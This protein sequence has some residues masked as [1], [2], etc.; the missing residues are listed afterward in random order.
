FADQEVQNIDPEPR[1]VLLD[2]NG[3]LCEGL[4]SN[5]FIVR[6]EE[7]LTPREKFVLP[8]VSRQTAIDLAQ[9]EGLTVREADL[10]LYDAYNA[11]EA[12]LTSTS[13]CICPITKINGAAI[14]PDG[15]VWGPVTRRIADAYQRFVGHDFVGQYLKHY[16]DGAPARAF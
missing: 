15:Q 9:Q 11:N 14:G 10:D 5:V 13:L 7:I 2:V 6:G 8:G 4:G 16:V 12:F 1:A 3:N